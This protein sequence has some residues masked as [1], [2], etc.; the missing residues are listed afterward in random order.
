MSTLFRT[1]AELCEKLEGMRKR[2]SMISLVSEFLKSLEPDEI[3]PTVSMILG[4]ALPKYSEQ[5]LEVSWATLSEIIR[6]T[7]GVDWKVF[8]DAF[9]KTGDIGAATKMV[10]ESSG[11]KRQISL[12]ERVL[13][14]KDVRKSFEAIANAVG[15][16]SREKKERLLEALLSSASPLEAKYLVKIIIGEMRTGFHEGLMEQA[17]SE[18]F[19]VPLEVVQRAS[20]ILGDIGVVAATAKVEG[21]E[22]LLKVGFKV[23]RPVK[24]ML[25]QMA[26]DVAEALKEHGGKTAFEYKL[27]GARVQI[28][29]EGEV[30]KIFSRRLTDVTESLPEIVEAVRRNIKAESAILEGEVIA[31]NGRGH[32]LPFQHLMR[33]FKRVHEVEDVASTIPVKLFLFDILYLNGQSLIGFP[34]LQRRQILAENAGE[35][36]LT[37]QIVTDSVEEAERFLK[38]ATDAGHEGLMAK[39]ID[40]DYVPG[41]RGKRW[42]KIK[43][44]LPPLDLVIVAA[45]YGYGKR[46]GWLSDYY[47]AARDAET[48]EFLTVGKTFKG[49]TD[50]EIVEMTKRLK[51]LAIREEPRRIFVIP[52]IVVEVA[53]NEI[54]KSPKYQCGMALRF[55]RITRIRDDKT[56]EEADTI[57]RV[58]E[59]YESQFSKKGNIWLEN[60]D[61]ALKG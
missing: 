18:A 49:L 7:T 1:L 31:V 15:P 22:G 5:T 21:K 58:R 14:I 60:R 45:E 6:R 20:M 2:T 40:S 47:L 32:P 16:G 51:E 43:P 57:Q 33:R 54:Q 27:D 12:F 61:K 39:K 26:N 29:K 3:E 24:L 46:H 25:A 50:A 56:P 48:G 42:L 37:K 41:I 34:Y 19:H 28:H 13:T 11:V 44:T 8:T 4:R 35:I 38:E 30:V 23:F 55:A 36:P 9:S 17:V 59:I 52:K 10:F 53:Y